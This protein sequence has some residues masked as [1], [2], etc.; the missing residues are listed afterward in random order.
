MT[1]LLDAPVPKGRALPPVRYAVPEDED[2]L[3]DLCSL[4]HREIALFPMSPRKTREE[5]RVA[6]L[7]QRGLI[8]VVETPDRKP[9]GMAWLA[10]YQE[11]YSDRICISERFIFVH[12][13]H[14]DGTP[15]AVHLLDWVKC[16][17]ETLRHPL[18]IGFLSGE[19]TAAKLRF[20]RKRFGEPVGYFFAHGELS[21][22]EEA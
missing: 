5:L 10:Q 17:S 9:A 19:R 2:A 20:Y 21:Q 3:F 4:V 22:I 15:H 16:I 7:K 13:D 12:P 1:M 14:R 8:G 6:I 18:V 11:W